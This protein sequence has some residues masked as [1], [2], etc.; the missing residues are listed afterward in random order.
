MTDKNKTRVNAYLTQELKEKAMS[1]AND[2]GISLS[3][4]MVIALNDY[5]KQDSVIEMAGMFKLL[6]S[7]LGNAVQPST[8]DTATE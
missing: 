4:L 2:L 8:G 6:Q 3:A 5:L 7:Q 1:K